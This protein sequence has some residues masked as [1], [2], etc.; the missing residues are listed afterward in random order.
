[1]E[2]DAGREQV[3][4]QHEAPTK[5]QFKIKIRRRVKL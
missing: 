1:M 5:Q 4:N 2:I 3:Q